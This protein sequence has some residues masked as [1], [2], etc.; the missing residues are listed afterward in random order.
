[1][2]F[3]G[4]TGVPAL[5][6]SLVDRQYAMNPARNASSTNTKIAPVIHFITRFNNFITHPP[7]FILSY[8]PGVIPSSCL[9]PAWHLHRFL[10]DPRVRVVSSLKVDQMQT[11]PLLFCRSRSAKS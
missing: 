6:Q 11:T 5:P 3:T 1:M 10:F 2:A 8:L 9:V 4:L 7:T